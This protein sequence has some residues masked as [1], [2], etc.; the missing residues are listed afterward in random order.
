MGGDVAEQRGQ[1]AGQD[2]ETHDSMIG[3]VH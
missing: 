1:R 2:S 3:L